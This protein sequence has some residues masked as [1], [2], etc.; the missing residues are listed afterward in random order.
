MVPNQKVILLVE[1][2]RSISEVYTDEFVDNGYKVI[3]AGDGKQAIELLEKESPNLLILDLKLPLMEGLEVI[4]EI[5]QKNSSVPIIVCTGFPLTPE[6]V[7]MYEKLVKQVVTKPIDLDV[8]VNRVKA[9][10]S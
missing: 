8:L 5:K 2:D 6:D 1:D 7:A 9:F 4:K 3:A 10:I